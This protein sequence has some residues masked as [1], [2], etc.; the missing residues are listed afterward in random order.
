MGM[1]RIWAVV[2]AWIWIGIPALS[3]AGDVGYWVSNPNPADR[4]HLR[5]QPRQGAVS[6]GKYYNGTPLRYLGEEGGWLKVHIGGDEGGL[7]GYMDKGFVTAGSGG[8]S[9]MPEYIPT[10][11][12]WELYD[13]PSENGSF[14]MC[15]YGEPYV[16]M[17]FTDSWW[18]IATQDGRLTGFVRANQNCLEKAYVAVVNNPNPADRLNLREGPRTSAA[19]LGKYYSGVTVTVIGAFGEDTTWARVRAGNREGYMNANYLATGKAAERVLSAIPKV[20]AHIPSGEQPRFR[21]LRESPSLDAPS[22]GRIESGAEVRV[23]GLCNTAP[24]LVNG[25]QVQIDWCHVQVG[26]K[27][28]FMIASYLV[29]GIPR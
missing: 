24:A 5:T 18:H 2:L 12:A 23:Y 7:E 6:L 17:G 25:H 21:E 27:E 11:S 8:K 14:R 29:P 22:L 1:K 13:Q 16:L 4:L 10:S 3:F 9:A 20:K 19:S 28:G 15:G 26:G